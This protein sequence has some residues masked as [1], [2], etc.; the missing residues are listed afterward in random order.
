MVTNGQRK[1]AKARA[2]TR[3]TSTPKCLNPPWWPQLATKSTGPRV[4]P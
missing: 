1:A 4:T 2:D 3:S